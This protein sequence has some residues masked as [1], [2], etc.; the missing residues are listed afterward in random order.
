[1]GGVNICQ[2]AL[3]GGDNDAAPIPT[4]YKAPNTLKTMKKKVGH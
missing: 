2:V 1:M 3:L 4:L